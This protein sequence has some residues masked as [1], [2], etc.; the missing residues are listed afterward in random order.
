MHFTAG[1]LT[2]ILSILQR[3][4]ARAIANLASWTRSAAIVEAGA[5][6]P[7]VRLLKSTDKDVQVWLYNNT[8]FHIRPD[9]RCCPSA[10]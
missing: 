8:S 6:S 9:L 4:A 7:L 10:C 2:K 3:N 1:D 5:I